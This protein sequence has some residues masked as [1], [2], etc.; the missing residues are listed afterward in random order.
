MVEGVRDYAIFLLDPQGHV[1]TWNTGAN[2][3]K[4]Y[5][6][7]EIIGHHFS[8]FYPPTDIRADKPGYELR[9]ASEVGRFED[10]GW[11]LRKDGT[12]FWANVVITAVRD[13]TGTLVGFGKVTRDLTER[14]QAEDEREVLLAAE[15]TSRV[16]AEA[17]RARLEAI[18]SIT[19]AGLIHLDLDQLLESLLTR[20]GDLLLCD[21]VWLMLREDDRLVRSAA[22]GASVDTS[23]ETS[24]RMGE[25][26]TGRV[27][28]TAAPA[29]VNESAV[30]QFAPGERTLTEM[31]SLLAVPL[32]V[33]EQVI[34]VVI[35]GSRR[36]RRFMAD[37]QT[38]LTIAADRMSLAI[39][40]ARAVDAEQRARAESLAAQESARL[41]DEFMAIAAH[42]LKTPLTG[43]R[44]A[45]QLAFRVLK[46]EPADL[47]ASRSLLD[48]VVAQADRLN[49]LVRQLL[50]A[51]RLDGGRFSIDAEDADVT[52]IVSDVVRQFRLTTGR[53]IGVDAPE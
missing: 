30:A 39:D 14:K 6:A 27:A 1:R 44:A 31:T 15:R 17:A 34:G 47:E 52:E 49:R 12:R 46:R 9:V 51:S 33:D 22:V 8:I 4:Q 50:E 45:A 18:Q 53:P 48:Q 28:E 19:E 10:E 7:D 23:V 38:L 32:K 35:V 13:R 5:E 26:F 42:E 3:I 36:F 43:L 40:H 16:E 37:D 25:G 11:R 41:R 21:A 24:V 2:R 29:V 20:V